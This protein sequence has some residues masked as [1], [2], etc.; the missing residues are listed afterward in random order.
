MESI[1]PRIRRLVPKEDA[2]VE[3]KENELW[4]TFEVFHQ[5]KSGAQPVHVGAVHAPNHEM[6]FVL[7][8]E[9]FGRRLPCVNLWIVKTSDIFTLG[10]QD[11]D[12]F[13]AATAPE[14]KY[15]D[16]SGFK[17]KSKIK[18]FKERRKQ[19]TINQ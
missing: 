16:A 8:K 2:S 6:A 10:H 13:N 11:A 3:L 15:R 12:M 18:A 17:V 4:T 1:D 14:K 19:E 7:A 9:Q 5:K